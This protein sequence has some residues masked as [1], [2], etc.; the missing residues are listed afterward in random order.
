MV[1]NDTDIKLLMK[2]LGMNLSTASATKAS[3]G[4]QRIE[5]PHQKATLLLRGAR[6][7]CEQRL[8][9]RAQTQPPEKMEHDTQVCI[10]L[11]HDKSDICQQAESYQDALHGSRT[12]DQHRS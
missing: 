11:R 9:I 2:I 4:E 3:T 6:T 8:G 10:D 7:R 12:K 1:I 5:V